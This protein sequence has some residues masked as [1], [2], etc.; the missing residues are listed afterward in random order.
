MSNDPTINKKE[1]KFH[2]IS[3]QFVNLAIFGEK[4]FSPLNVM[5]FSFH[6]GRLIFW[7]NVQMK[8]YLMENQLM[9]K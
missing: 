6:F 5:P 4:I 7:K 1:L 3:A 8:I 2:L 9:L